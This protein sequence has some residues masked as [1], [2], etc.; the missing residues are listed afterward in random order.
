MGRTDEVS[1]TVQTEARV[2]RDLPGVPVEVTEGT[3]V[4]AVEGV[5]GL[6]RDLGSVRACLLDH[7]VYRLPRADIV[8]QRDCAPPRTVVGDAQVGSKL[9]PRPQDENHA[10]RL[11]EGRLL[12]VQRN[13]PSK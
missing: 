11:K 3:G 4:S 7:L 12:D 13:R 5:R 8:S 6:A 10:V 2:V 9:V 1:I